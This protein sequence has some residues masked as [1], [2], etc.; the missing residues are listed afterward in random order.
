MNPSI[1]AC[2]SDEHPNEQETREKRVLDQNLA[3]IAREIESIVRLIDAT[4]GDSLAFASTH[5]PVVELF[6]AIEAA[7]EVAKK[8]ATRPGVSSAGRS[9][10]QSARAALDLSRTALTIAI[11]RGGSR[12]EE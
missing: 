6:T 5:D 4:A 3:R 1:G 8:L 12:Y 2:V 10:A 11:A 9:A 7:D